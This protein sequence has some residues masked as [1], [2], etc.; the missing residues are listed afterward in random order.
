MDSGRSR[1]GVTGTSSP[2]CLNHSV[3]LTQA[4]N[5]DTDNDNAMENLGESSHGKPKKEGRK[6][7]ISLSMP[8]LS[9]GG[10]SHL[11]RQTTPRY[12]IQRLQDP[13]C[14]AF[15]GITVDLLQDGFTGRATAGRISP[16]S[17]NSRELP[18]VP[19]QKQITGLAWI[20]QVGPTASFI[21]HDTR[22]TTGHGLV[23]Y[24]AA[25][26]PS[27]GRKNQ[28]VRRDISLR[29]LGLIQETGKRDATPTGNFTQHSC[30]F[31]QGY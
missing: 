25:R 18:H 2:D 30:P 20:D 15:N 21:A 17:H 22:Q 19:H 11:C 7:M 3:W 6:R 12:P 16:S 28:T 24:Q 29:Y 5:S 31:L 13:L 4:M 27:V 26:F 14:R 9:S 10:I 8:F 1:R 23:D